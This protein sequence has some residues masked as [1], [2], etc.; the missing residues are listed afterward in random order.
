MNKNDK[1]II[2]KIENFLKKLGI[3]DEDFFEEV[4][5]NA[6]IISFKEVDSKGKYLIY[7]NN[8]LLLPKS[9]T[10]PYAKLNRLKYTIRA[11]NEYLKGVKT[12][13]A[14]N[15]P[16]VVDYAVRRIYA[17]ENLSERTLDDYNYFQKFLLNDY[18]TQDDEILGILMQFEIANE[19]FDL[20]YFIIPDELYLDKNKLKQA[21]EKFINT[22]KER[23]NNL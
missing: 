6:E 11:Y 20:G 2:K 3:Y 8:K 5:Y 18:D 17:E 7:R 4:M 21:K 9:N 10:I 19:Y 13:K 16:Y 14:Y 23:S 15:N 1:I 22:I 12:K